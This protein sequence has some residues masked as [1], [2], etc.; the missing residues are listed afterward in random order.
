MV[1][2]T[3]LFTILTGVTQETRMG[4]TAVRTGVAKSAGPARGRAGG[5]V[6]A[7]EDH[8]RDGGIHR[9]AGDLERDPA[10]SRLSGQPAR[11]GCF[12]ACPS[13]LSGRNRAAR[14]WVGG[15]RA[16]FR[17]CRNGADSE[18]SG[19]RRKAPRPR[20]SRPQE[21]QKSGARQRI[22]V[23]DPL[24]GS[25]GGE[26][27]A[28]QSGIRGRGRERHPRLPVSFAEADAA[29]VEPRRRRRVAPA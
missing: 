12:C 22:R 1:G 9:C 3:S 4:S 17:R 10:R 13:R 23:A 19:G 5:V 11:R 27:A 26:H 18:R 29:G 6:S 8:L 7:S 28:A 2:K 24:Q 15:S 16:G 25:A 20:G 21:N 14:T